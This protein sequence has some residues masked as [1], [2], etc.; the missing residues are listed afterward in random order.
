MEDCVGGGLCLSSLFAAA[1]LR[2]TPW[3]GGHVT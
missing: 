2:T 1:S 3:W